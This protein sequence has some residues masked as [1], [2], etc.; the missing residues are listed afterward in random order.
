MFIL[1]ISG[2]ASLKEAFPNWEMAMRAADQ[3]ITV[4][5]P[6]SEWDAL[7][8]ALDKSGEIHGGGIRVEVYDEKMEAWH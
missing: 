4:L 6:Q 8:N 5:F 1:K 2:Q 3:I 7:V